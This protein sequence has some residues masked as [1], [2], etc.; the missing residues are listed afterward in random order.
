MK[1]TKVGYRYLHAHTE[2]IAPGFENALLAAYE[3]PAYP[4]AFTA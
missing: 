2:S 1:E 3:E 4:G